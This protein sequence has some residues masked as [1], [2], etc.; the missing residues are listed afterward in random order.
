MNELLKRIRLISDEIRSI[1]ELSDEVKNISCGSSTL[2][3]T[4][5]NITELSD[6]NNC[7]VLDWSFQKEEF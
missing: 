1:P 6:L 7:N 3:E 5:D 4:L 2:S